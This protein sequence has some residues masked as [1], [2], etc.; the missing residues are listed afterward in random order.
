MFVQ[1]CQFV[2]VELQNTEGELTE[3][4]KLNRLNHKVALVTDMLLNLDASTCLLHIL[5]VEL[6]VV[7]ELESKECLKD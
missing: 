2:V 4:K 7:K 5:K 3:L 1:R 6:A